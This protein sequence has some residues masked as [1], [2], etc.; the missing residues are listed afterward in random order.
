MFEHCVA[1][2]TI[3]TSVRELGRF[4]LKSL[5]S[6]T[7]SILETEDEGVAMSMIVTVTASPRLF[8]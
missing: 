5:A 2:V 6:R 1:L 7:A 3:A 4:D 8:E